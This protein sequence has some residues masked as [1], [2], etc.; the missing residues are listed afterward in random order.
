MLFNQ[1]PQAL[2]ML[3]HTENPDRP[4]CMQS[5]ICFCYLVR[6]I[7]RHN[8]YSNVLGSNIIHMHIRKP[9][10]EQ[11]FAHSQQNTYHSDNSESSY[12]SNGMLEL[13]RHDK[14]HRFIK[15]LQSFYTSSLSWLVL[16]KILYLQRGQVALIYS[17]LSTQVQ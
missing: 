9:N 13:E 12:Q 4:E 10:Q 1:N 14:V 17:H 11:K 7:N 16:F 8:Q 2:L 3:T 6:E 15:Y 5:V